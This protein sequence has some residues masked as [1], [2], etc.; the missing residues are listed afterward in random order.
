MDDETKQEKEK[1]LSLSSDDKVVY[2][3]N[4]IY[5]GVILSDRTT[6]KLLVEIKDVVSK[7]LALI[8]AI[9]AERVFME[10]K[11]DELL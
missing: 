5:A 7:K 10:I 3:E 1:Y 6:D 4:V 9:C 11:K 2:L 8:A